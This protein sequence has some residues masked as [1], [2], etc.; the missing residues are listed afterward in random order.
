[1]PEGWVNAEVEDRQAEG[2]KQTRSC[3]PDPRLAS[4]N[5]KHAHNGPHHSLT[6]F[7]ISGKLRTGIPMSMSKAL[8]YEKAMWSV[9]KVRSMWE[10][11][12][13]P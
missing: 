10:G 6:T 4:R 12:E 1:M 11:W 8:G 3:V 7:I 9:S 2:R 5:C 13:W